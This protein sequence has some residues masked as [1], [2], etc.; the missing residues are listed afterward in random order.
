MSASSSLIYRKGPNNETVSV[1]DDRIKK[2][3]W[4]HSTVE[5]VGKRSGVLHPLHALTR[6]SWGTCNKITTAKD[7]GLFYSTS[8]TFLPMDDINCDTQ[9]F[10]TRS[11]MTRFQ[12]ND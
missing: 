8:I 9:A 6:S 11:S 12:T 4:Q 1:T 10:T 7:I 2:A 5:N 3:G